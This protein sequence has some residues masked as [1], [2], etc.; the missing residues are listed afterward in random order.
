M[1]LDDELYE[2]DDGD[3]G[4]EDQL[5]EYSDTDKPVPSKKAV[6]AARSDL[7]QAR[8]LNWTPVTDLVQ[9]PE[10]QVK[11]TG[12]PPIAIVLVWPGFGSVLSMP[13]KLR[14]RCTQPG[15][16][17]SWARRQKEKILPHHISYCDSIPEN[18]RQEAILAM[19]DS[20]LGAMVEK[21]D[22]AAA[23]DPNSGPATSSSSGLLA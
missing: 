5:E 21:L 22:K 3:A 13:G 16:G 1:V 15:C 23:R 12:R 6:K 18:L 4:D 8:K 2:E 19:S 10:A 14:Y 20:S 9:I 7:S 17:Q 11:A